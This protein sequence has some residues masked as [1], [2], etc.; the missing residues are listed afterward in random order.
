MIW[1]AA[2]F[3]SCMAVS[4]H[5]LLDVASA[6]KMADILRFGTDIVIPVLKLLRMFSAF[7]A[8]RCVIP[9]LLMIA[10]SST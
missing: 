9:K 8:F 7:F 6:M 2:C 10:M 4:H 3:I 5:W 1:S